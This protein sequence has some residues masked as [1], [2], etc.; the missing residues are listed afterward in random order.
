MICAFAAKRPAFGNGVEERN[1]VSG[2]NDVVTECLLPQVAIS[3][4][5]PVLTWRIEDVDI[6]CVLD[7]RCLRRRDRV[8]RGTARAEVR[9]GA[10]IRRANS[11]SGSRK[12]FGR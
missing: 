1:D 10:E 11:N 12:Y 3:L 5:Q 2:P 9:K 8:L 4:V 6:K 7:S